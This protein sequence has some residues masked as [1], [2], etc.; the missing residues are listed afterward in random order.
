MDDHANRPE[1]TSLR[2]SDFTPEEQALIEQGS[3]EIEAG[4]YYDEDEVDTWLALLEINP[5]APLPPLQQ[6][7]PP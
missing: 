4:F 5:D 2:W 6:R 3:A 7:P 1:S